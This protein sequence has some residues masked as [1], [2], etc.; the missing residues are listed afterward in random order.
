MNYIVS[1]RDLVHILFLILL[2]V[3][4]FTFWLIDRNKIEMKFSV[5]AKLFFVSFGAAGVIEMFNLLLKN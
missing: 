4:G 2:G 1:F 5:I 3:V